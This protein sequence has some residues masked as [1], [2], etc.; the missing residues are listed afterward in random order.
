M[1]HT[2]WGLAGFADVVDLWFRGGDWANQWLSL[3]HVFG[4]LT[5]L[6]AYEDAAVLHGALTAVGAAD[7]LPFEPTRARQLERDVRDLRSLLG[8]TQFADAVRRGA[9]M[10]DR[11]IVEF[12][13]RQI[14]ALVG[15]TSLSE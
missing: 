15:Q 11:E 6:G 7:A 12:A 1:V 5:D 8:A 13:K 3:R 10:S 9:A 2:S 14:D 4:I